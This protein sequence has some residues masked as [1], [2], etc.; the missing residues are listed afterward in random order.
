LSIPVEVRYDEGFKRVYVT[1]AVGGFNG[2]DLRI[3]FFLDYIKHGEEPV[4]KPK[5]VREIKMEVVLS[6]LAA[7]QLSEWLNIQVQNMEKFI[8][9]AKGPAMPPSATKTPPII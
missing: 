7:K 6:P 3:A 5:A 2:Y 8:V 4:S 1:G 9:E